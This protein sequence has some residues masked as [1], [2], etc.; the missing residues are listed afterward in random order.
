MSLPGGSLKMASVASSTRTRYL[1]AVLHFRQWC[2]RR[3]LR[4]ATADDLDVLVE[5]YLNFWYLSGG[6][7]AGARN[8]V[9]GICLLHPELDRRLLRS[10]RALKGM[11]RLLPSRSHPPLTW[12]LAVLIA[13]NIAGDVSLSDVER[14]AGLAV[15]VHFDAFLR[16]GEVLDL[17]A[18]DFAAPGDARLGVAGTEA[19]LRI[20]SAKTGTN[21]FAQLRDPDVI[22]LVKA[23]LVGLHPE[24]RIFAASPRVYR[25]V[26]K[27]ALRQL[28]LTAPYV[29]HSLRHGAATRALN[30]GIPIEDIM[31]MGR[32]A[33]AKSCRTYLQSGQALLLASSVPESLHRRGRALS[34][35]LA[36]AMSITRSY[37]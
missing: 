35:S 37:T 17:R 28:R 23:R 25:A 27:R 32:W 18:S 6:G 22:S 33:S 34:G 2:A 12:E 29:P 11:A 10:L 16:T 9:Y 30:S 26:F 15:L 5:A 21:Q 20:R 1:R 19:A 31:R 13:V 36:L 24:A 14:D 8:T 4:A 7:L 3:G